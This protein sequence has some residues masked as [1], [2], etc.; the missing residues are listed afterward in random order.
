MICLLVI[1]VARHATT[2]RV[3]NHY[4][5]PHSHN[6]CKKS[7]ASQE[8]EPHPST[9]TFLHWCTG[10]PRWTVLFPQT[11]LMPRISLGT[12]Q[13][14]SL[15]CLSLIEQ[16]GLEKREYGI[17]NQRNRMNAPV[18]GVLKG[19]GAIE[20]TRTPYRAKSRA[21]GSVID[22]MAPFEAA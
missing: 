9:C 19:P 10:F 2:A 15:T 17:S 7:I 8:L 21:I 13:H 16:T 4:T 14:P 11:L 6:F 18:M 12:V 22:R 20:T 1:Y 3:I 5:R